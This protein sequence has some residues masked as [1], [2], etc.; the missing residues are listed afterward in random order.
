MAQLSVVRHNET[1]LQE[2]EPGD[3]IEFPREYYSHWA[4]Y[5]GDKKVV[6]LAG[7]ENDG[8]NGQIDADKLMTISGQRFGK[9]LVKV[10]N[11]WNVVD[12]SR[13]RKNNNKDGK[14]PPLS[15]QEIVENALSKIGR[16]GYNV[17]FDNCE[18]FAKWCRYGLNK[19]DQVDTFLT[20]AAVGTAIATTAGI[21]YGL[22][23]SGAKEKK[24]D[25]L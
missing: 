16:I 2:L 21:L 14:H 25:E 7:D 24:K 12:G 23:R 8:I 22:S 9:A 18:H 3:L 19:S 13:A 20:F 11:F 10:E 6:H 1:L 17:L 15:K 4:V 5:I